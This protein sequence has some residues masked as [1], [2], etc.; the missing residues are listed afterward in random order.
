MVDFSRVSLSIRMFKKN[1]K[2][3]IRISSVID[4]SENELPVTGEEIMN[5]QKKYLFEIEALRN[6]LMV[7]WK[8]FQKE[9]NKRG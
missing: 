3:E 1:G 5:F 8:S 9:V 4:F 2:D 6:S 7:I